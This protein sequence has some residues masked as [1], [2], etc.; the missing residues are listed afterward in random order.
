VSRSGQAAEGREEG[1]L[2]WPVEEESGGGEKKG[3]TTSPG[4]LAFLYRQVE[5]GGGPTRWCHTVGEVGEGRVGPARRS[6]G[7]AWP[8]REVGLNRGGRWPTGGPG[9]TVT[10]AGV[11]RFKPFAN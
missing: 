11:Q 10:A 7:A 6:G 5:V 1:V 9:A 4:W 8:C 2:V 3:G